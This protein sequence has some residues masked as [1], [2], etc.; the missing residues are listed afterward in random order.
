MQRPHIEQTV[1]RSQNQQNTSPQKKR[2]APDQHGADR[3]GGTRT[4]KDN[5]EETSGTPARRC[6][7]PDPP[8]Y[9]PLMEWERRQ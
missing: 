2:E 3:L 7:K 4:G 6:D 5:I 9:P 8:Y 1:A